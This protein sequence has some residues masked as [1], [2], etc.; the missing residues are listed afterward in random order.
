MS[1]PQGQW[2]EP[3]SVTLTVLKCSLIK[4]VIRGLLISQCFGTA[5]GRI[6]W[7]MNFIA[8]EQLSVTFKQV[9]KTVRATHW[10]LKIDNIV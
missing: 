4:K 6:G 10:C 8:Y 5:K 1:A 7:H 3:V 2:F 9:N